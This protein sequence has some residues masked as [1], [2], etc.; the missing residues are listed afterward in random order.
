MQVFRDDEQ[1]TALYIESLKADPEA[2]R[3]W[4]GQQVLLIFLASQHS[5]HAL[6]VCAQTLTFAPSAQASSGSGEAPL[7]L[8]QAGAI[9]M[10][11]GELCPF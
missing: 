9:G 11:Q 7:Q 1:H 2:F 3:A 5:T 8:P 4:S 6:S 10:E